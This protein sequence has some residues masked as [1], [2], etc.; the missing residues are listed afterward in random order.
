MTDCIYGDEAIS[1]TG[2][3]VRNIRY[4]Y[5]SHSFAKLVQFI[6]TNSVSIIEGTEANLLDLFIDYLFSKTK[7][8]IQQCV[9]NDLITWFKLMRLHLDSWFEFEQPETH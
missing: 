9:N 6:L 4:H 2:V 3:V 5:T 7:Y 8:K 1:N